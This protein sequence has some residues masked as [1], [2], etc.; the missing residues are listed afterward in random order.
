M[1]LKNELERLEKTGVVDGINGAKHVGFIIDTYNKSIED[2][3][4]R[5]YKNDLD[6]RNE[7]YLPLWQRAMAEMR[8]EHYGGPKSIFIENKSLTD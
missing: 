2:K 8:G 1:E 5:A 7:Y 6:D 3:K 4:K